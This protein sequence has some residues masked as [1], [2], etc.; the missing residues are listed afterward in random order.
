MSLSPTQTSNAKT[1]YA[2]A[3]GAGLNHQ[4]AVEVAAAAYSES[5]LNHQAQG[6]PVNHSGY[7]GRR[8][9]GLFQLLSSGYVNE[10]N[11]RGGV[12]NPRANTL[13]ILDDYASY[14]KR[15]PG[16]AP[17]AA[18]RDVERSG[19][20][21]GFYTKGISLL[22][23]LLAGV[24]PDASAG[25][26]ATP[27]A[28][29]RENRGRDIAQALLAGRRA[30]REGRGRGEMLSSLRALRQPPPTMPPTAGAAATG[31]AGMM[32]D[33]LGYAQ[34]LGV[35]ATENPYV[36]SAIGKHTEGSW[37]HQ[38]FPG[39][40]NGRQLGRGTDFS[41]KPQQLA[42]LFNYLAARYPTAQ[43]LIYDPLGSIFDGTR[44]RRPYGGHGTHLH[45]AP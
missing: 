14:W 11:Q 6:P 35:T 19:Q 37:H 32:L 12:F 7:N 1:I 38:L 42:A 43:E 16:A 2:L 27:G 29:P 39:T 23:P 22:D 4:R 9:A 41:G 24:A 33:A 18:A 40:Y 13:A 44:S 3:R 20:G 45:F 25:S 34:T 30:R 26:G 36:D 17:G 15:N 8:A 10:A 28:F 5:G 21:A 31:G